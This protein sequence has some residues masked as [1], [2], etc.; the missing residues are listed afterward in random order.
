MN[1]KMTYQNHLSPAYEAIELSLF[2]HGMVALTAGVAVVWGWGGE[3]TLYEDLNDRIKSRS[4]LPSSQARVYLEHMMAGLR[5]LHSAGYVHGDLHMDN[6]MVHTDRGG[7][8]KVNLIDF[9]ACR[10][11]NLRWGDL[12]R[13]DGKGGKP[14]MRGYM[15][16]PPELWAEGVRLEGAGGRKVKW[17][18]MRVNASHDV[19]S[20]GVAFY[21]LCCLRNPK[22]PSIKDL[23]TRMV[24]RIEASGG[25]TAGARAVLEAACAGFDDEDAALLKVCLEPDA[26]QRASAAELLSRLNQLRSS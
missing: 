15:Q 18:E 25:D 12:V 24:A 2:K 26:S 20:A 4:P 9:G 22:A 11:T 5:R 10:P 1:P 3:R 23:Q 17:Q 19:W 13:D 21:M 6:A 14:P 7:K 16:H 8:H